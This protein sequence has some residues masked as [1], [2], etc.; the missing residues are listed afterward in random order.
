MSEFIA[1]RGES[2][3]APENTLA[4]V[5]LAWERGAR[6]VE[7][8]VH[9]TA[10]NRFCVIHDSDTLRTT[11]QLFIVE[12][13]MLAELQ[14]LDAGAWKGPQWAGESIPSLAQVLQGVPDHGTLVVEIK[15]HLAEVDAFVGELNNASL[16]SDQVEVISFHLETLA[17]VKQKLPQIKM[18]WLFESDHYTRESQLKAIMSRLRRHG[19]DGVNIGDGPILTEAYVKEFTAEGFPVYM[20]TINDPARARLLFQW[21][22][23]AVTTDRTA[24]MKQQIVIDNP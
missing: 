18:L 1:H 4:A 23:E 14:K 17:R 8:D 12:K 15:P 16:R 7:V 11:G 10:D 9:L 22:V 21:G 13:S 24:W 5:N 3:D 19:L 6:M 20:Y 2:Y